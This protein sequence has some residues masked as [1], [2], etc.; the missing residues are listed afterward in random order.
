MSENKL[1]VGVGPAVVFPPE[2]GTGL[3]GRP[4]VFLPSDRYVIQTGDGPRQM[5]VAGNTEV[6]IFDVDIDP[7]DDG[8][9]IKII[10]P[11]ESAALPRPLELAT[12]PGDWN[13][14]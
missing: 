13:R 9:E 7:F 14:R 11:E 8:A 5:L 10:E 1:I 12:V 3:P 4:V 2:T 6:I